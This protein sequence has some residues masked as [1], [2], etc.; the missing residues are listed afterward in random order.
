[1]FRGYYTSINQTT[2]NITLVQFEITYILKIIHDTGPTCIYTK[3]HARARTHTHTYTHQV[4]KACTNGELHKATSP[5]SSYS[6][7]S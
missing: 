2:L 5:I 7:P 4:S 3:K 6:K 1:M